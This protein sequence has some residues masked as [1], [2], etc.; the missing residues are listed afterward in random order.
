M[1]IHNV[2]TSAGTAICAAPSRIPSCSSGPS[3]RWR[4]IFSIV[5]VASS[6]RMPTAR[7]SPPSVI[8]LIVWCRKLSTMIE[9]RIES[10]IEMA[11]MSVLRQLPKN[12][13]DHQ[14]SQAGGDDRFADDTIDRR[15]H[16]D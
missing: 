12:M 16:K 13:Q 6:T 1:Q 8:M 5:T 4:S 10:G 2:E 9:V 11:M 3:S 7:A 15:P 14:P